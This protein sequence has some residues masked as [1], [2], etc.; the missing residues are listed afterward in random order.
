MC[1]VTAGICARE[2]LGGMCPP[3]RKAVKIKPSDPCSAHISL[4]HLADTPPPPLTHTHSLPDRAHFPKVKALCPSQPLSELLLCARHVL[5]GWGARVCGGGGAVCTGFSEGGG[6]GVFWERAAPITPH[7][8]PVGG[9][10]AW[11]PNTGT[12]CLCS[13]PSQ[14]GPG[15]PRGLWGRDCHGNVSR[16]AGQSRDLW[17]TRLSRPH[18]SHLPRAGP[19]LLGTRPPDQPFTKF[20]PPSPGVAPLPRFLEGTRPPRTLPQRASALSLLPPIVNLPPRKNGH[21]VTAH[22]HQ[23]PWGLPH[24]GRASPPSPTITGREAG[25]GRAWPWD[26]ANQRARPCALPWTAQRGPTDPG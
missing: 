20:L 3:A 8:N 17:V 10:Q 14:A 11:S 25:R 21:G 19:T 13:G 15:A 6:A 16:L 22:S 23:P 4:P 12:T 18:L 1:S 7:H 9:S 24:T 5:Q 26:P 2:P